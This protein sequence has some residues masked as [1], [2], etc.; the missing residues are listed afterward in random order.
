MFQVYA[1]PADMFWEMILRRPRHK[2]FCALNGLSFDVAPGEVVGVIG[3]NGAGKS[4]LLRI[5]AGTLDKTS[6]KVKIRGKV[7]AILELGTG[8]HPERTGRENI[9]LGGMCLGMSREEVRRKLDQII[10]FSELR[11]VIDQPFRTYS[12]GMQARLTF[13]T[14]ISVE[15]DVLIID[16]ALSAGDMLFAAKCY[17]RIRDIAASGATVFFVTHGLGTIYELCSTAILLHRGKMLLKDEP[18]KVGYEYERLLNEER[19]RDLPRQL[20]IAAVAPA[21][22]PTAAEPAVPAMLPSPQGEWVQVEEIFI[23]DSG[24]ERATAAVYG[25]NCTVV[26]RCKFLRE[27]RGVNVAFR[28][29]SDHGSVITGDNTLFRQVF[30][31][32]HSG[33]VVDVCFDFLCTLSNGGYLVTAGI[34]RR[35][36]QDRA[37]GLFQNLDTCRA[38]AVLAVVGN[39]FNTGFFALESR[40]SVQPEANCLRQPEELRG[41]TNESPALTDLHDSSTPPPTPSAPPGGKRAAGLHGRARRVA[42]AAAA[43]WRHFPAVR[44]T[45]AELVKQLARLKQDAA[46]QGARLTQD[47]ARLK[48]DLAERGAAPEPGGGRASGRDRRAKGRIGRLAR[49]RRVAASGAGASVL[50]QSDGRRLADP[51]RGAWT[52]KPVSGS[53]SASRRAPSPCGRTSW[54]STPGLTTDSRPQV[55]AWLGTRWPTRSPPSSHC[56]CRDGAGHRLRTAADAVL[57]ARL[58]CGSHRGDRSASSGRRPPFRFRADGGRIPPLGRQD[59]FHRGDRHVVGPR[60]VVGPRP[61]GDSPRAPRRRTPG[62]VGEPRFGGGGVRSLSTGHWEDRRFSFVPF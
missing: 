19:E 48:Q 2:R 11:E 24:G 3:R 14:A 49:D 40:V 30:L 10:D 15:P 46:E 33:D 56:T 52:W 43:P 16:E 31:A 37:A 22:P 57:S 4:T 38:R 21:A 23:R 25:E 45:V 9:L 28:V 27:C 1:Q 13:S 29:E 51:A 59:V 12:S 50:F 41:M 20:A 6:G 44:T 53:F 54:K 26:V 58:S 5:L 42:A 60:A 55:A 18:R 17:Q 7:S 47:V 39:P 32:G 34:A 61:G 36:S 35:L 62:G 8:F